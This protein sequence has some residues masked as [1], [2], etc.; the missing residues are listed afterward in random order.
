MFGNA[1]YSARRF[2]RRWSDAGLTP[3]SDRHIR[4]ERG[5]RRTRFV[6]GAAI[7][8][9]VGGLMVTSVGGAQ[10]APVGQGFTITTA[11]L[12][13]ILEQIKIAERH[14]R[15]TTSATGP[16]AT[17]VGTDVDQV[18]RPELPFGLRT[19]DGTCNNLQPGQETFGAADQPF[20]R[21]TTPFFKT[22]EPTIFGPPGPATTYAQTSGS[23]FDSE[24]RTISNLIVDQ[25]SANP[26]AVAAA[27]FPVRTQGNTGVHP[28]VIEDDPLTPL[29]DESSPA[30]CVP[31]HKTL[32]IPNVTTDIGLSPPYNSLFTIFGQFFDHGLDKIT[33]SSA[34]GTVFVPLKADDPLRVAGPDG[35]PGNGDEVPANQAFM[36]LTRGKIVTGAD[37]FRNAPN[38]DSPFVD[39]SQTY[40]SHPSHQF[41]LR[42]YDA[43][44]GVPVSTGLFLSS[45]D[46]GLAT[47]AMIK[48]QAASKL[49][50]QLVDMDVNDIPMIAVDAYGNF[51]PGPARGMPQYVTATGFVEG[52]RAPGAAVPAPANVLRIGTAFLNDIAHSAAPTAAG[53]DGVADP[54]PDGV[55]GDD[56]TTFAGGDE[57]A[58]NTPAVPADPGA[59]GVFGTNCDDIVNASPE[60]ADD[61]PAVPEGAGPD[62]IL[63][64]D[65]ATSVGGDESA[66]DT[67][68]ED[69]V[70]GNSLDTPFPAGTYDD[71]LLDLHFICGDGRCNE[72]IALSAVHQVFHTEHDRLVDEFKITIASDPALNAAYHAT[73]AGT[74]DFG[75]RVFQAARFVTEMEYQHLVFEEFARKVQPA[76]NP[77]EPFA[78]NQTDIN[79]AITAEYA[80]A[81]YRFGHSMLDE[82]IP[83]LNEDGSSNDIPLLDGFLNPAAY[84]DGGSAGVLTSKQAAGAIIMGLSDQVGNELDEFVAN[85]LRNN[86]LGLPLDLPAI[87]MT[88]ARSEGIP[89][90]NNVRKQLF[91]ATNDGQ[92]TPYANWI[93]YGL[94][95]KHPE[96]LTNFVAAY[97]KHPT[98]LAQ[99]TIAGKREAARLIVN[100]IS[101]ADLLASP[102]DSADFMSSTGTWVNS[103][104]NST[105]GVDGIDLWVGGLAEMTNPF[106][107]LLGTTFNY[108]FETQLTN[109]QNGDR[110]YYLGRTP[111]MN[112]RAQLEGNSFAELVMRNTTAH[113]L[114]ADAFATADCK[115]QFGNV[116]GIASPATGTSI[117]NDP[118]TECDETALLIRMP[119][120]QV[121]YRPINS[122]DPPGINAQSV[123]NGTAGVDKIFGGNDNDTFLG[124]EGADIIDGG[125]GDDVAIGGDGNDIITD[126]AGADV[127]KGGDG[128]DAIDGGIGDD[129]IMG[130]DGDDFTNGGGNLNEHFLGNGD[131]FAIAGLGLDAVFGGAGDDWMEGGDMPD[132]L[133]GDSSTFFFD[134]H[135]VPGNDVMIGQ[136]GDDDGDAEG[137]DD[138]FVAGPGIEKNAGAAGWDWNIGVGDPQPLFQD[139]DQKIIAE[140]GQPAIEARDK[141]NEVEALSGWNL[142]DILKGDSVVPFTV[143][144]AGTGFIGCDALDQ[145]GLDRISG[146]DALVP[147]LT[148]QGLAD[149]TTRYCN[150]VG[151]TWGDGNILLGGGGSDTIEGRGADDIIDG[152]KYLNV[153]LTAGAGSTDLMEHTST[154]GLFAPGTAGMTLQQAVFAGLVDP[155]NINIVREVV[156]PA[157]NLLT[158]T[159]DTALFSAPFS[160]AGTDNYS[161]VSNADGSVTITDLAGADGVDILWNVERAGFCTT[162]DANTGLCTAYQYITIG[163]PA[164]LASASATSAT[165]ATRAVAAGPATPQ[166]ITLTNAGGGTLLFTS[167]TITG[168]NAAST[169]SF[170]ST[171]TC[172]GTVPALGCTVTVT[173][174]PTAAGA[175]SATLNIV[176]SAGTVPVALT[177]TGVNNTPATGAPTVSDTTPTEGTAITA[178]VGTVADVD[179]VPGVVSYQWRQSA[180][181]AGAVN[182]VIPAP[183]G[184]SPTFTP[185]QAQANRRL[186]VTVTFVDNAGTAEART[187]AI[188]TVVGDLFVGGAGVDVQTGTA[189]Q[190]VYH[191]GG[192]NDNLS[193]GAE[194]DL[195]SGDAGDDTISTG[196]GDDT[197]TFSATNEGFDSVTGGANVDAIIALTDNTTIGLRAIST[198]ENIS[199]DGHTG[200]KIL[201]STLNDVL[202]FTNVTLTGITEIDGG[203]GNDALT[204]SAAADVIIGRAGTDTLNG[205][206]GNDIIEGGAGNDTMNGGNDNDVFRFFAGFGAIDTIAGFDANSAGGQDLIVLR[207]LGITAANFA[208]NVTIA[209]GGGGVTVITITGQ[210]TIRLTGVAAAAVTGL[211]VNPD[212][213][214]AP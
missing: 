212:F 176:T 104:P 174:D 125:A 80:H 42:D 118:K 194:D 134:D 123:Y 1:L 47:W 20:P 15:T 214:L 186:T 71:E 192:G 197:I 32:F 210:G 88:R 173:F 101:P 64:D 53:G 199:A 150:I 136:G 164:P 144:G 137:G 29:V 105:T 37:G 166:V 5:G 27:G 45:V 133:I 92:L 122:V 55:L 89:S 205:G 66:D 72:N 193:T 19:V 200:V 167:A 58:D 30:D 38:T 148:V 208:A 180:T 23:V 69:G 119:N 179:G 211:G 68:V 124:N 177:G 17:L 21:M 157:A 76:I 204:G 65:P 7:V 90:L 11:D 183:A 190:D 52:N 128:N 106:G 107:G 191:G 54:G 147:P 74:F 3:A 130:G 18:A 142:D 170:T 159:T 77:F 171:T 187:S 61:T 31:A 48:E 99:T 12:S 121:R 51:I 196:A 56:P 103:G 141:Y 158:G 97:G 75:E 79:P 14:V 165:F 156:S 33:N 4:S 108:V 116:P 129:I 39:Q 120:G 49:G 50:M 100:P 8:S 109:L 153:R 22:A 78:L 161:I 81:V 93:D 34:S 126:L 95:L 13:Y 140:G 28:C 114:K 203:G 154:T 149:T 207:G 87:N 169:A 178:T 70:A 59:D 57:S 36:V 40:T 85:T 162:T 195:V 44:S 41:F 189:G 132:L 181:P 146:L 202:N 63:L 160:V 26:A 16:C 102:S 6:A 83:R 213:I 135:D 184:T 151:P 96:S 127:P 145:D 91:A 198:V 25:T 82:D 67:V 206:I 138:I 115:F 143:G 62:G 117:P 182:V 111:G 35:I 24:P 98:I 60:C 73:N 110:F 175:L 163:G 10:A 168:V 112:L 152:D 9:L 139:L 94:A 46:G 43:T 131:D 86:L 209:N 188:T 172:A 201:G 155:G 84:N 2:T 113:T 185:T